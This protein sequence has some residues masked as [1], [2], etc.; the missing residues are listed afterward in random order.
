MK[1]F[2]QVTRFGKKFWRQRYLM[3]LLLP[4]VICLVIFKYIPIA[5]LQ[6]AFKTYSFR[7]GIWGSPWAG[8][9][10]FN[11]MF[12]DITIVPAVI[13]TLGIS[14]LKLLFGF[15]V[16]I[17]L[18]LLLNEVKNLRFKKV[19][20]TISYFPYFLAYSVVA[21][22]L[23]MLL[24]KTGIINELLL[25]LGLLREP[26]LFLGEAKAFWGVAVV[27]DIWKGCGWSSIIYL[28]ALTSISPSLYESATID[29]AGRLQKMIYITLPG[30]KATV[31]VLL[32]MNIGSIVHGA[33]FDLSYLLGNSLNVA[34]SEILPTYILRTGI[35]Y[36]RFSYATAV[37][38]VESIVSLI[39]VFGSNAL[40]KAFLGEGLF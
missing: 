16:P 2:S 9:K 10:Q 18:A 32:I 29:G 19:V 11:Q 40:S 26:Y 13:N 30:I 37:G 8:L 22:M 34:R 12:H 3:L 39:L 17:I 5:G 24:A 7:L 20:Q 6:I 23:S 38:L 4:A 27:T 21:L 31:I 33:N 15:P 25:T 35:G 28:A 1:L 36:G 14:S